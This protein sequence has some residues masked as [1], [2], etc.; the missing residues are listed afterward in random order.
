MAKEK[1]FKMPKGRKKIPLKDIEDPVEREKERKRRRKYRKQNWRRYTKKRYKYIV[2]AK[3]E[4]E[5]ERQRDEPGYY[6]IYITKRKQA[7]QKVKY[8]R[9]KNRAVEYYRKMVEENHNTVAFPKDF[10][11]NTSKGKPHK[12]DM[13]II[14]VRRTREGEY[15]TDTAGKDEWGRVVKIN[16]KGQKDYVLLER[17]EW[18]VEETF[19][20]YGYH[21]IRD[22]KTYQFI[23]DNWLMNGGPSYDNS[24]RITRWNNKVIIKYVEGFD[25]IVCRTP[26]QAEQLYFKMM[27]DCDE[28]KIKFLYFMGKVAKGMVTQLIDDIYEKTGW[29]RNMIYRSTNDR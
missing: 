5:R 11:C 7:E 3:R 9:W 12:L 19:Y 16:V 4:Y 18:Y 25:F 22:Q 23:W 28:K 29:D 14:L 8:F 21:P 15:I 2:K 1:V 17:D 20:C 26:V 27:G 6:A 10:V 13:E 24:K